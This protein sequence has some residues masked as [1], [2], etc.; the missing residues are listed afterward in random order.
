[1]ISPEHASPTM[2]ELRAFYD[3][4]THR[5]LRDFVEGNERVEVGWKTL[6]EWL[7]IPC[8][9]VLEIGCGVGAI[10]WRLARR[11]PHAQVLGLDVSPRSVVVAK[12]L[13]TRPNL[14]FKEQLLLPGSV[15]EKYDCV[16]LMDVYEHI[17]PAARGTLHAAIRE[18]LSETGRV[19]LTFPAPRKLSWQ[20]V[21]EPEEIQPVDEEITWREIGRSLMTWGAKYC[22]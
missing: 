17:E 18:V 16:L 3:S 6:K 2:Q 8:R 20:R 5:K 7:P 22:A 14:T 11:L 19:V 15:S 1:M 10:C 12:R 9:S 13:F 4:Q 21:H